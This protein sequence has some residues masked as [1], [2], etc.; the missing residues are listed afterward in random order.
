MVERLK[1]IYIILLLTLG[2]MVSFFIYQ[3]AKQT[4]SPTLTRTSEQMAV[5]VGDEL[6]ADFK[7]TN[8]YGERR[9]YIYALYLN[10]EKRFERTVAIEADSNFVFGGR[11]RALEPGIVK[12]SA[13]IY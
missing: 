1:K 13:L 5:S 4:F 8:P 3:M 10:D 9:E 12:V 6:S 2:F 7:I 11:Y